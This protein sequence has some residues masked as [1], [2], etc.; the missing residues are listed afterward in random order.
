[1]FGKKKHEPLTRKIILLGASNVGKTT[2]I[3][4]WNTGN[5]ENNTYNTIGRWDPG[6]SVC[7]RVVVHTCTLFPVYKLY[8]SKYNTIDRGVSTSGY[9]E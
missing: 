4:R 1:M 2:L 8:N 9:N 3:I 6:N 5:Y 7:T